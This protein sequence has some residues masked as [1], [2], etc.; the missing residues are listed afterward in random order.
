[1]E[2][3]YLHLPLQKCFAK[4]IEETKTFH[5]SHCLAARERSVFPSVSFQ[6]ETQLADSS[7]SILA[8]S[9]YRHFGKLKLCFI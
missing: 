7:L 1:M 9:F 2:K 6:E 4:L 5:T 8:R 3:L